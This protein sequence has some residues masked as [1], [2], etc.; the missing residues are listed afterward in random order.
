LD[1]LRWHVIQIRQ[2]KG[3]GKMAIIGNKP[4]GGRDHEVLGMGSFEERTQL[5][6]N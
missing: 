6:G 3:R 5:Y 2:V 4:V 1:G